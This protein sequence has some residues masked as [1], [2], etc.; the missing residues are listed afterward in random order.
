MCEHNSKLMAACGVDGYYYGRYAVRAASYR[1]VLQPVKIKPFLITQRAALHDKLFST[2][3]I[4]SDFEGHDV[5]LNDQRYA[6]A[7]W[8]K[9]RCPGSYGPDMLSTSKSK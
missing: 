4:P 6:W 1:P 5:H 7:S 2:D 3:R 8:M 9:V